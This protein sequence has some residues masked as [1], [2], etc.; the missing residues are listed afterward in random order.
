[1]ADT[2]TAG[3]TAAPAYGGIMRRLNILTGVAGGLVLGAVAWAIAY[4]TLRHSDFGSDWG[5]CITM[6]G[7]LLCFISG[8]GPFARPV[9]WL[10]GQVLTEENHQFLAGKVQGVS[11]CFRS[12]TDH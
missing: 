5:I 7:W 6:V 12:A 3:P 9:R 4:A 2:M 1:M 11:R 8:I 10:L